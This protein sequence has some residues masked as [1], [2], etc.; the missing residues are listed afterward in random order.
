[1]NEL[2]VKDLAP[3]VEALPDHVGCRYEQQCHEKCVERH[4]TVITKN[5]A[6]TLRSQKRI[7]RLRSGGGK[8]WRSGNHEGLNWLKATQDEDGGWVIRTRMMQEGLRK[9]IATP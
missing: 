7:E 8:T 3:V 6:A 4:W 2:D 5:H 9:L 1:M